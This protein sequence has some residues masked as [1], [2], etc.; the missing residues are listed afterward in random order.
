MDSII[1]Q[2]KPNKVSWEGFIQYVKFLNLILHK[3]IYDKIDFSKP[4]KNGFYFTKTWNIVPVFYFKVK[5]VCKL[6]FYSLL[7]LSF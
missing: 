1:L 7:D 6:I 4:M 3:L 5:A 2:T